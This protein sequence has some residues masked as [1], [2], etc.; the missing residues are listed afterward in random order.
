MLVGG[1]TSLG[2]NLS[3]SSFVVEFVRSVGFLDFCL[4]GSGSLLS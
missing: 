4:I 2:F 3:L 1:F